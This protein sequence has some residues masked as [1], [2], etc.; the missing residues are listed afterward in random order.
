MCARCVLR[1]LN[2]RNR[3]AYIHTPP[4]NEELILYNEQLAGAAVPEP[5]KEDEGVKAQVDTL[6]PCIGCLGALSA[7]D[8]CRTIFHNWVVT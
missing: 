7:M 1:C 5:S 2:V 8:R 6:L 3:D 4:S